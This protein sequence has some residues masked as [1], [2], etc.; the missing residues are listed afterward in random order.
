[1]KPGYTIYDRQ[2]CAGTITTLIICCNY[3]SEN[4]VGMFGFSNG[5]MP[6]SIDFA[7]AVFHIK[8]K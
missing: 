2:D 6:G 3:P 4:E 5:Y 7:T 8:L 1:M